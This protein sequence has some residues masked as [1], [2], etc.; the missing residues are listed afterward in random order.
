MM[1][2]KR[3]PRPPPDLSTAESVRQE[4]VS[5]RVT[6]YSPTQLGPLSKPHTLGSPLADLP[7]SPLP[8]RTCLLVDLRLRLAVCMR[9]S[10]VGP[11]R[12]VKGRASRASRRDAKSGT[13][14]TASG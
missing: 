7:S 9:P 10:C 14:P 1:K 11:S 13:Q 6:P 12:Q 5:G 3:P 2:F 4:R 8:L